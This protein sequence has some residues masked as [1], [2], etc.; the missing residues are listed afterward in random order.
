[1]EVN[2]NQSPQCGATNDVVN[3]M[4][5]VCIASAEVTLALRTYALWSRNRRV[6][7][8]LIGLLVVFII[9]AGLVGAMGKFS[10]P[11]DSGLPYGESFLV[12]Q[13]MS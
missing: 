5:N 4:Y 3:V 12:S 6:L 2:N 8:I 7:A 10:L 1:M 13:A 9:A 11:G